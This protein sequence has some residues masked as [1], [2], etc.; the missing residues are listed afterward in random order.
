MLTAGPERFWPHGRRVPSA[1]R[2]LAAYL[3]HGPLPARRVLEAGVKAGYTRSQ[4]EQAKVRLGI[5]S[6]RVEH[7]WEWAVPPS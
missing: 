7:R 5:T 3:A 2:W 6:Q 4:I 1:T